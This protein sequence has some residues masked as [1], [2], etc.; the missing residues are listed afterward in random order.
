MAG[1]R[2]S[3]IL[4][5]PTSLPGPFGIGDLGHSVDEFIDFLA[6]SG[7][8][9]WQIL[10]LGPTGGTHS[11]YQSPS[12]HAGSPLLISPDLLRE[13]GLISARDLDDYPRLPEGVASY[14][15]VEKAK[16][17]L[18]KRAY[19]A[20][21]KDSTELNDFR[22]RNA[23][24]LEDFALYMALKAAHGGRPWM[25]WE[26]E[27]SRREPAALDRWRKRHADALRLIV[28]EQFLFDQQWRRV[29]ELCRS[30]GIRLIGDLPIYVSEDGAEAW[31]RRELFLI[32]PKGKL[33]VVAGV[34]PDDFSKSGQRWGNPLYDW[35]AHAREDFRWWI[36]RLRGTLVRVDRVRFDHFIG[37]VKYY[38]IPG[39]YKTAKVYTREHGPGA[40]FLEAVQRG[41]PDL[42]LIAEDLGLL[43]EETVR[44]RDQFQLPGMRVLQFV[45]VTP[46][47]RLEGPHLPENYPE[48]CIAYTGTHDNNT[49]VGWLDSLPGRRRGRIS[50]RQAVLDY[51]KG[52]GEPFHWAAIRRVL[53][54]KAKTAIVPLQDVLGLGEP[55]RMNLPGKVGYWTW[56]CLPGGLDVKL[57]ERLRAGTL[58]AGRQASASAG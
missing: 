1:P 44:L 33:D 12:S 47:G 25:D 6:E 31:A 32:G 24:W 7:Q 36:D 54:T 38:K 4:L 41:I 23:T 40:A 55:A 20:F 46:G 51:L 35:D 28:F 14:D 22:A 16:N 27:L 15:R 9:W 53:G 19:R 42:P 8:S 50:E 21:P 3:G 52:D 2:D 11:P 43:D 10:P 37:L 39:R 18:F 45:G 49:V 34:P 58:E 30:R 17:R 29:R 56:R 13:Q 57:R 5:H 26:P 48:N